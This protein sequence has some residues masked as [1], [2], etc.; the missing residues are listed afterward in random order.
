MPKVRPLTQREREAQAIENELKRTSDDFLS[1]VGERRGR[2]DMSRCD[3][4]EF[5]GISEWLFYKWRSEGMKSAKLGQL[6][7]AAR[8]LGYRIVFEP[9]EG[10]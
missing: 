10:K 4:A 8:K 9:I 3:M 6:V 2:D 5:I 1:I 7:A